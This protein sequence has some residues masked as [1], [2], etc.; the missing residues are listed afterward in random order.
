MRADEQH[1]QLEEELAGAALLGEAPAAP[2]QEPTEAGVVVAEVEASQAGGDGA[3]LAEGHVA[4]SGLAA[5]GETVAQV[6]AQEGAAG[7]SVEAGVNQGGTE[8]G[9]L[10]GAVVAET[11]AAIAEATAEATAEAGLVSAEAWEVQAATLG[12][13]H[14]LIS[15]ARVVVWTRSLDA[16]CSPPDRV[17]ACVWN[18]SRLWPHQG[19]AA[20]MLKAPDGNGQRREQLAQVSRGCITVAHRATRTE[21]HKH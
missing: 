16:P 18:P 17:T 10:A 20:A 4:V 8:T 19:N 2:S 9:A 12:L 7:P 1:R 21:R 15:C 5:A 11:L 13:Q 14:G 6:A 3:A